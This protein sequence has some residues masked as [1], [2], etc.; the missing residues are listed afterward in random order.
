MSSKTTIKSTKTSIKFSNTNKK[1]TIKEI[2]SE[3]KRVMKEF[4]DILWIIDDTPD[5]ISKKI[6]SQV[7]SWFTAALL[8]NA[9]RQASGI[10]R[11]CKGK[12]V[13]RKFVINKLISENKLKRARKL[14]KI[15]DGISI[16]K[17]KLNNVGLTLGGRFAIMDF[18]NQTSFD[19][20]ITL[21][22]ISKDIRLKI[23]FKKTKHFNKLLSLGKLKSGIR[24]SNKNITFMFDVPEIKKKSTGSTLGIDI[25]LKNVISCSNSHISKI[26]SHGHDLN[27]ICSILARKKGESKGFKRAQ[28]HRTNYINWS[29]NQLNLDKVKQVN[30]EEIKYLRY[31]NKTSKKLSHWTYTDI[32]GKIESYCEEHGVHVLKVNPTYTS[33]RCSNCGFTRKSNRKGKLFKCSECGYTTDADLNASINISLRLKPIWKKQR[34]KQMNRVGFYWLVEGQDCIV[35]VV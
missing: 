6:Y 17:P 28:A 27:S 8:Q 15:Y 22:C 18:D 26:N 29:I 13:K 24:L 20:W 16:S 1:N 10:V 4:I 31:K 19:G 21:K 23:P 35:P 32:F 25:G 12:Q 14:Q 7:D 2:I 5:F 34:L 33:Q 30:I 11:Q 9:A 3:Y